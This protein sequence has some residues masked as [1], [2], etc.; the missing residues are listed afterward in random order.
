M[1][2]G[3]E[4]EAMRH[5]GLG[6]EPIELA[7][8]LIVEVGFAGGGE[9]RELRR[10]R[11]VLGCRPA[12]DRDHPGQEVPLEPDRPGEDAAAGEASGVDPLL[13]DRQ[14]L[15]DIRDHGVDGAGV[16]FARAVA[17]RVVGAREDPAE[18]V[19]GAAKELRRELAARTR[20]EEDQHRPSAGRR[21]ALR[22]VEL[23]GL[24]GVG[25]G[26]DRGGQGAARQ[27]PEIGRKR[28]WRRA[29]GRSGRQHGEHR[30]DRTTPLVGPFRAGLQQSSP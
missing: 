21:E 30:H 2:P 4:F 19:G 15:D 9:E 26:G 20:V 6:S 5:S 17:H 25:E 16:G 10:E 29:R 24:G 7:R 11:Q 3:E 1:R 12:T 8:R 13:V 27:C 22:Q 14:A 23:P 28:G 18:F